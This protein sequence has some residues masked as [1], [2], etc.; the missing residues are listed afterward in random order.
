MTKSQL[1]C[2]SQS[3]REGNREEKDIL[4]ETKKRK[5]RREKALLETKK[6]FR[7]TKEKQRAIEKEKQKK[8]DSK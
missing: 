7:E 1:F 4:R 6:I 8:R 5:R 2:P 3:K